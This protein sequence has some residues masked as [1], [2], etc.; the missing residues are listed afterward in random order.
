MILRSNGIAAIPRLLKLI[1]ISNA[2]V[3]I[4][5]TG[6]QKE[7]AKVIVAEGGDY[8][9]QLK[10]NQGGLHDETVGSGLASP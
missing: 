2:V 7:I 4:N 5:A 10:G 9:L 1:D 6:C 3:T 8:V